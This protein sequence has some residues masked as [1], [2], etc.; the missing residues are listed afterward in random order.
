MCLGRSI[1][2]CLCFLLACGLLEAGVYDKLRLTGINII[3]RNGL[4][5]TICSKEKLQ[6]YAKVDFLSPQPYQKVMRTYK[7]ASGEAVACLTTYYPNGQ[8]RQYLECLNNRAFGRYREWHSNGKIRIQ[9]EVIGGIAD[10]HPSAEAGWL[11]DG[12]TYAYDSDGRL[13]AVICYEKGF[14]EGTSVYY[15][16]NGNVWKECPYHKGVAHGDFFVFTEEG[17]LLKKQTYCKGLLSGHSLRYE[18]GSQLLLAEEEYVQGKLRS[19][20][21]YDPFTKEVI[22]CVVDGKGE[23]AIYGRYAVIETRTILRGS[24]H[25]KVVLF[26]ESGKTILQTYSLING[27]KEGEEIFFYPGGEGKKM[28]LTWSKGI[29]QGSV[30]TWYPNG[31]LES[32]KELVQNKKNGLL[33]VYYPSGQI[34]A[35]EE[36]VE[37]LLIKGEY[38]RPDDRY[39]YAKVEK[40]CG[41]AVFFSATGGLLK[42]VSYEDGKPIVN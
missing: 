9:A 36:Y 19:G 41:T 1:R 18:P 25:G 35:T 2:L 26:D 22:A 16:S 24:P 31:A 23:Q 10:L 13:E 17:N 15:H 27:Q 38:F 5:E 11:F 8:I 29:L 34:M 14:L 30:K 4:S 37:D 39:P 40:G 7:N 20:K 32:S 42:K 21:Y 12:T 33:M 28:L 3:D 6:K